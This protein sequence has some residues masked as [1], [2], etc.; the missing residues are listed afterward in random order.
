MACTHTT[1]QIVEV[2]RAMALTLRKLTLRQ[3][4][5]DLGVFNAMNLHFIGRT[6]IF[7][8]AVF[9]CSLGEEQMFS[10]FVNVTE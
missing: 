6:P 2:K 8:H 1:I 4:R 5:K 10:A 3:I 7:L 9:N